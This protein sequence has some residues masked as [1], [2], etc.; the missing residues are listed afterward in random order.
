MV[1]LVSVMAFL[2]HTGKL[3]PMEYLPPIQNTMPRSAMFFAKHF[4]HFARN[5]S[6]PKRGA[7]G[8]DPLYKIRKLLDILS[9]NLQAAFHCDD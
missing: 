5:S 2:L 4:L 9:A 1:P 8:F 7:P 3:R 6:A